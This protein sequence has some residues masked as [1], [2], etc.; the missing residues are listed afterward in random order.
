MRNVTVRL[1]LLGLIAGF[2]ASHIVNHRGEG[3]VLDILLAWYCRRDCW[4]LDVSHVRPRWRER[5]QPAQLPGRDAWGCRLPGCISRHPAHGVI[6][7][8]AAD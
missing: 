4:R 3:I 2:I 8:F 1:D 6:R 5:P 7:I